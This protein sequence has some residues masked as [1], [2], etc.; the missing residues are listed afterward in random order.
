VDRPGLVGT[1][2]LL[3]EGLPGS[4][5]STT[6]QR[7]LLHL[8][9]LGLDATWWAEED[10]DH[11]LYPFHDQASLRALL[12]DLA[13]GEHERVIATA[14]GK[15]RDFAERLTDSDGVTILD[16]CLFGYLT[17][18]LY[19]HF[20]LPVETVRAYLDRVVDLIGPLQPRLIYFHQR[21]LAAA[22]G[23]IRTIRGPDVEAG[24]VARA[25]GSPFGRRRGLAGFDGF[26]AYWRAWREQVDAALARLPFPTLAIES[27]A[28]DWATYDRAIVEFLGLPPFEPPS[29]ADVAAFAGRY[30]DGDRT[31]R[32]E[33]EDG[34]LVGYDLPGAFH[35]TRLIPAGAPGHFH[36]E[37]WSFDVRFGDGTMTVGRQEWGSRD[38]SFRRVSPGQP[39]AAPARR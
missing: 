19:P 13:A 24:Y 34:W 3:V 30:V 22:L 7:L 9:R 28:G 4:G 31:C 35:R 25:T 21:D 18:T 1:R 23:R 16:A 38:R 36:A 11:P 5:K 33:V 29:P 10:P 17:W 12:D 26:V 15:W 20:D 14:L 39:P 37:T 6:G 2:L 8:R 27:S 32:V